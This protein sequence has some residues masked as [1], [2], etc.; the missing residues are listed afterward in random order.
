M[1]KFQ[2]KLYQV[3]LLLG[4][5]LFFI[6]SLYTAYTLRNKGLYPATEDISILLYAFSPIFIVVVLSYFIATLYEVPSLMTTM[7][8][9]KMIL[10]LHLMALVFGLSVFY[11]FPIFGI[12]PKIFLVLQMVTYTIFQIFWRVYMSHRIRTNKKR[13]A[14]LVGQGQLFTELKSAVN[15]NPQSSL[16]FAEHIEVH[17]PLLVDT[18]LESLRT[19]LK[20]NDI[21]ILVVDVRNEKVIPLLPYFY[22]LVDDGVRIYDVYK[23]YEDIF[24]R[25][26]LNSIGYFWFF[27]NVT[28]DMRIYEIIKRIVDI[29]LSAVTLFL[30][31]FILPF[32]YLAIKLDDKGPILS[33][34]KR[35]GKGGKIINIY[36]IR[37]MSFTDEGEWVLQNKTN[38][39]TKVGKFLRKTRLD[40]FPQLLNV[41]FGEVSLVGP[42]SD[43]LANGRKLSNEIPFYSMRYTIL[44]G[45]SGWAQVSQDTPPNSLEETKLRLQ[46]DLFYVKNRSLLL[47]VVIMVRTIRVLL[48]RSGI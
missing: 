43:I 28:L 20:E 21:S 36:K 16:V 14:L 8:R 24:R 34:Q 6:A 47:D 35:F 32:I 17:S 38:K 18:S 2:N 12:T 39:I 26:P 48:M 19:V 13:K 1:T 4:D 42:R 44:P 31:L 40:E 27:E 33:I 25:T 30:Y 7:M 5:S 46:Y 22:N 9:V 10:R 11:I 3:I 29:L 23:M 41:L 37:T 45:L 15:D